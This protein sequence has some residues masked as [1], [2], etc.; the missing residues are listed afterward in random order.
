MSEDTTSSSK[1]PAGFYVVATPIGNLR[2]ITLRALDVLSAASLI[3][4]E[5]TR[6]TRKLLSHYKIK[7]PPLRAFHDHSPAKHISQLTIKVGD[8][9]D[10]G[11]IVALVSDAGTPLISDPGFALLK[12]LIALRVPIFPIPGP[13]SVM[14]ALSIAG[15]PAHIFTFVGFLPPR[16]A[17]RLKFLQKLAASPHT[18]SGASS[19][20]IVL[21]ESAMRLTKSL[22]DLT[23]VFGAQCPAFIAREMTKAFE[24]KKRGTLGELQAFYAQAPQPKGEITMIIAPFISST[25]MSSASQQEAREQNAQNQRAQSLSPSQTAAKIARETGQ[26]RR[27]I[28]AQLVAAKKNDRKI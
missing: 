7:S 13:S 12:P 15:L 26:S 6:R 23:K 5:D 22:A 4:A 11:G 17:A 25:S 1:L 18:S 20:A 19:G 2:D 10:E 3:L 9:V 16:A 14:A 24:E 27:V 28:Y 8:I 21:F